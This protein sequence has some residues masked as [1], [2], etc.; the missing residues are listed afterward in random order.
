MK[1]ETIALL[2]TPGFA[3]EIGFFLSSLEKIRKEWREAA[4]NLSKEE[5]AYKIL[6]DV[7]PIGTII[8]HIA[9]VEYFWI[10]QIVGGKEFT[11]EIESLMHHDLWFKDFAAHDLDI[12]YCLEVVEKIHQMTQETLSKLTDDDL[13]KL[14]IRKY[15][16]HEKH[17]TL[18]YIFTHLLD[19]EGTHKGQILMIKRLL[20]EKKI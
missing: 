5:L 8:I 13:E 7:Q 18:R 15:D 1:I 2:P 11:A 17:Y 9:E 3:K 4:K 14:F 20:K 12:N 6:P 10:Q 16:D 19:H